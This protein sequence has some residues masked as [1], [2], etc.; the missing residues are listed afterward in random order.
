[1]LNL[2]YRYGNA[3]R[4]EQLRLY[5]ILVSHSRT[6]LL[7]HEPFHRPLQALLESCAGE[8]F[9]VEVEK[10]LVVLLNQLCVSLVQHNQLLHLFFQEAQDDRPAK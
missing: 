1:M 8:C 10:R 3:L 2:F 5:E 4:L 6:Q 7:I 9:S